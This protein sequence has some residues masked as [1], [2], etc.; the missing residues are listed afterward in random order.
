MLF[1]STEF[2]FLFLPATLAGFFLLMRWKGAPPAMGW[3]V[4]ASL[5]FYGY[6][7]P[8]YVPL[9]LLS[10][11]VNFVL[12][13]GIVPGRRGARRCLAAGIAFNLGLL[14]FFKYA[15]FVSGLAVHA[16]WLDQALPKRELPL[17]ISFFTFQ[18]IAYLVDRH[19]GLAPR[20]PFLRYLLFVGFFPQLIAGPIV[21]HQQMMP[22][23]EHPRPSR[24]GVH[25]GLFIFALG[26][27][28]KTILAD[29]L[30]VAVEH[31]FAHPAGLHTVS[32][33]LVVLAY[34]L[35]IYFDFSGY[36]DMAVGLG[37]LFGV[38]L[39]WNFLSPY[40][41][42][43]IAGFWRNWHI[44]L[45]CFLRDYLFIPLGGSRGTAARTSLNLFLTMLLGGIWHGAGWTF[46]LW[47]A[48]HGV[49]LIINHAWRRRD[50]PCPAWV[51]WSLTQF[52]VIMGWVL[53]RAPSLDVAGQFFGLLFGYTAATSPLA[54]PVL[55]AS[56][57]LV[58]GFIIAFLL[59]N[60]RAWSE[61]C[62]PTLGWSA[63]T[64]LVLLVS[65]VYVLGTISPPEFLYYDF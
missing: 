25:L 22:Q 24:A 15:S 29:S 2:I 47:G 31:G 40:R 48:L 27:A 53:F 61:R 52:V 55:K 9:L 63:V 36:S 34:T 42:S 49:A 19:R 37:K 65:L 11:V 46:I 18:Q 16:G 14:F 51:G 38:N 6:W 30:G 41:C 3:L 44:T 64:G 45:S 33:W 17:G 7:K 4:A 28:K 12:A 20:G 43:S 57:Y 8:E 5:L 39:P 54:T 13:R 32:A 23:L 56:L 26:L 62:R 50:L 59:P 58:P 35:Q 21:H 60:T 10:V 1:S